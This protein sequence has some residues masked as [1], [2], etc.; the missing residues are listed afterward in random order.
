MAI[1]QGL[2]AALAKY[3]GTII[4]TAFA[5]AT[6]MLF[7]KVPRDRQLY[8]SLSALGSV[9]WLLCVLGTAFPTL[10]V[11]LLAFAKPP[12]WIDKE[13]IRLAMLS[14]AFVLPLIV[15]VDTL[16]SQ[17][18]SRR[19][20]G[21][22]DTARAVIRAYPYTIG[23]A[24]TIVLM[25]LLAPIMQLR[26]MANRWESTH[27]PMLVESE[28]YREVVG[29]IQRALAHNKLNTERRRASWMIR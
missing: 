18:P 27:I 29:S 3:A 26:N 15:G 5:W 2:L 14:A 25:C 24:I 9:V 1:L 10:A 12:P 17:P 23:M 28:D 7:G 16:F 13:W 11:F 19:P 8:V 22:R 20:K 21:F 4:N 6:V